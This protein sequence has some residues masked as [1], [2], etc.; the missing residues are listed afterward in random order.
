[1]LLTDADDARRGDGAG[2]S[3]AASASADAT[4]TVAASRGR[5]TL[6]HNV[7]SNDGILDKQNT[8]S[9]IINLRPSGPSID[10]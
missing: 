8:R 10:R 4:R 7:Y 3:V 1:M 6:S 9:G 2:A 5:Q